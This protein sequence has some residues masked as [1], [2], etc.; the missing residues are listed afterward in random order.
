[1]GLLLNGLN[2]LIVYKWGTFF[3]FI[4][5]IG[6]GWWGLIYFQI[7][8]RHDLTLKVTTALGLGSLILIG[9]SFATILLGTLWKPALKY[10]SVV[11][12]V[13]GLIATLDWIRRSKATS[14]QPGFLFVC[15][16][17]LF[18]LPAKMAFLKG[19]ILPPYD[20]S[21]EHYLIVRG[22]LSPIDVS[23][24]FFALHSLPGGYYH[25]GFHSL[26]AWISSITNLDPAN[27]IALLGQL[28]LVIWPFSVFVLVYSMTQSHLAGFAAMSFSAFVWRMPAF[29][30]NWGKY[31]T[32]AGLA[33]FPAVLGIWFMYRSTS[34]KKSYKTWILIIL[35]LGLIFVHSRL[36]ICLA[37]ATLSLFA[38]RQAKFIRDMNWQKAGLLTIFAIAV[39]IPFRNYLS[40]YY[41][42]GYFLAL[43]MVMILLPF[44]ISFH[45]YLS[46]GVMLFVVGVW[47]ATRVSIVIG[48]HNTPLLDPPF[49]EI[50]LNIPLSILG[51][52]G[53]AGLLDKVTQISLKRVAVLV[54]FMM[55]VFSFSSADIGYPDVCCNYISSYDTQA[56]QWMDE[57]TS[58][59]ASVWIAGF[60][61]RDYMIATD[62]GAW[63][64]ALTGRNVNKIDFEY[65]WDSPEAFEQICRP[66]YG[67]V[68][69]YKGGTRNSFDD[70]VLDELNW[71][72]SVHTSGL[73]KIYKVTKPCGK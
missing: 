15:V 13:I 58:P 71:L 18:N 3:F 14:W 40:L 42:N 69:V 24:S 19:I 61:P 39:F 64:H 10:G 22:F 5:V 32:I 9:F 23:R 73:V 12:L 27:A 68:F 33:L 52:V 63:V 54:I 30:S 67:D 37:L 29:A 21:P 45:P 36:A 8:D 4:S 41:D 55:L 25:L 72:T 70:E 60:K 46:F 17:L 34:E 35:S 11:V 57:N 65:Q 51:G 38:T 50:L 1:M 16:F 2:V 49:V 62:G 48:G 6:L 56:I 44:G 20:D 43:I 59:T 66:A 31:P 53:F 28:F 26:A 47:V 7:I